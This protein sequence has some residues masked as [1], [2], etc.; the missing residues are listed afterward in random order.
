[1]YANQNWKFHQL[2]FLINTYAVVVLNPPFFLHTHP[3]TKNIA[4]LK[5][6]H[7][8]YLLFRKITQ[9]L[10]PSIYLFINAMAHFFMH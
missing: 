9:K 4:T 2:L 10:Q 8:G 3:P 5:I 7:H 1:M 6:M